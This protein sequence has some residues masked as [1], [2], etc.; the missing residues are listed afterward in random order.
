MKI[1]VTNEDIAGGQRRDSDN[2][3]VARALRRAGVAHLGV[4]GMAVMIH[5]D[6]QTTFVLMPATAQEWIMEFDCGAQVGPIEF[7]LTFPGNL[8]QNECAFDHRTIAPAA[9]PRPFAEG[10]FSFARIPVKKGGR[11]VRFNQPILSRSDRRVRRRKRLERVA[12]SVE[13]VS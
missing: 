1:T 11:E 3:P 5:L 4:G 13:L 8:A 9:N 10:Q 7:D 2:C 12:S 6:Q